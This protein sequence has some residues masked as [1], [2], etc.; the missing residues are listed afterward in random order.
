MLREKKYLIVNFNICKKQHFFFSTTLTIYSYCF[1][2]EEL[3][4]VLEMLGVY[5]EALVQY[6]ELD[7]LFTQ[8][9]LNSNLG[10]ELATISQKLGNLTHAAGFSQPPSGWV[11]L[12]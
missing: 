5:E 11:R 2:Q 4:F 7:A 12:M 10:G 6:D 1:F 3:A 9:I 8:F